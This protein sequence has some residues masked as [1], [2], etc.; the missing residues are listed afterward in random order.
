MKSIVI[1]GSSRSN[2]ET[3]KAV[4]CVID[5]DGSTPIID[6][7]TLNISAYDYGHNNQNDDYIPLMKKVVQY[8]TILLATPVYWYTMSATMKIFI[9]RLSDLLRI[10]KDT[11]RALKGKNLFVLATFSTSIP[12]GF[13]YPF[14]QTCAY[15]EIKY[16]GCSLI[17]TGED[18]A[19]LQKNK[20]EYDRAKTIVL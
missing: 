2:G 16:L 5:P 10:D 6:L 11:G 20:D 19:L 13:E 15:M 3:R 17:H 18:Q 9:D 1:L 12:E 7:K 8:D 4:D 14:Q